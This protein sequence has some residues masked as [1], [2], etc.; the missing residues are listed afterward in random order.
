MSGWF[1]LHSAVQGGRFILSLAPPS[2]RSFPEL[3]L[4]GRGA[5]SHFRALN[6]LRMG[7]AEAENRELPLLCTV[8]SFCPLPWR[9]CAAGSV[10][11][12]GC[13][14]APAAAQVPRAV[15]GEDA[16]NDS[17]HATTPGEQSSVGTAELWPR[18]DEPEQL[19]RVG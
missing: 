10:A 3:P 9:E 18:C 7:A 12:A 19:S 8:G 11:P 6:K 15:L 4:P 5:S 13:H 14:L 1:F 16:Q 17:R 2:A